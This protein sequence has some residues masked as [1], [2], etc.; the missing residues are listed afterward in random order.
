M[1]DLQSEKKCFKSLPHI[2]SYYIFKSDVIRL[3]KN[4]FKHNTRYFTIFLNI[5]EML[6][7]FS[8]SKITRQFNYDYN[9]NN[10]L[11]YLIAHSSC[12]NIKCFLHYRLSCIY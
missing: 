1:V 10:Y 7:K 2:S 5:E 6:V 8:Y 11:L 3:N 4:E 9:V 12:K